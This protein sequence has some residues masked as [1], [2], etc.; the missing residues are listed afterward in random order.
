MTH[1]TPPP[2]SGDEPRDW[3]AAYVLGSLTPEERLEYEGYLRD[4]P[5]AR[6]EMAEIAG[7]PALLRSLSVQE[8]LELLD[9]EATTPVPSSTVQ[10]IAGRIASRRRRRRVGLVL[11]AAVSAVLLIAGG[12]T[13]GALR[14]DPSAPLAAMTPAA[15]SPVE[16]D[17]GLTAK[18][19][20]TRVDWH[21]SYGTDWAT[22]SGSYDLVVIDDAGTRTTVATWKAIGGTASDLSAAT[23]IA[24][25]SIRAVSITP[26]GSDVA[27][28]T[29]HY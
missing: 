8:A 6:A 1:D 20:G 7:L 2:T 16:A 12:F 21:C 10:S 19:W 3:D 5:D 9:D 22:D 11:V 23:D 15:G 13:V 29:R 17:I 28:A 14:P 18:D 24:A 26:A 4:R 27:L 25:G